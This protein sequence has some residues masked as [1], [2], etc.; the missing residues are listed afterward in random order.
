MKKKLHRRATHRRNNQVGKR[1]PRK[2]QPILVRQLLEEV[3]FLRKQYAFYQGKCE[4]LELAAMQSTPAGRDYVART[5][6]AARPPI[7]SA[8]IV[9]SKANFALIREEWDKL[10]PVQQEEHEAKGDWTIERTN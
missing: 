3:K 10:S 6:E 5:E 7:E 4:R 8:P 9:P 2:K 1:K